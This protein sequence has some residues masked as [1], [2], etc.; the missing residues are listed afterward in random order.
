MYKY[1]L[2]RKFNSNCHVLEFDPTE[3]RLDVSI[4]K[5]NKLE[6]LSNINGEPS[7]DEYVLAKMNGGFFAMNGSTEYLGSFVDDGKYYNKSAAYYPT[8]IFWKKGNQFTFEHDAD[9]NRHAYYQRFAH[10]AIGVS[11]T[12]IVN[13]E[14]DFTYSK[15]ELIRVFGHPYTKQPRSL[16]GQK[17]DG[18]IVWVV[19]D[20]RRENSKGATIT[21]CA[22]LMLELGCTI[23]ANLDGGGSSEMIVNNTIVNKPS[24]GSERAIGTSFMCYGK[25]QT[26]HENYKKGIV[27]ATMLNVRKLPSSNNKTS[28]ILGQLKLHSEVYITGETGYWWKIIY[29]DS[30]AYVHKSWIKLA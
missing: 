11:W 4:G 22:T 23:A 19:I 27:T 28:K 6:R 21:E 17:A 15:Q 1:K 2:L 10:F 16:I 13:G 9:Q 8:L 3:F 14:I 26:G 5:P 12:L 24:D 18:N 29:G 7:K 30:I 20:G 25:K